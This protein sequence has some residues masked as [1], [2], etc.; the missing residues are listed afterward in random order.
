MEARGGKGM[1][2]ILNSEADELFVR[3]GDGSDEF[4]SQGLKKAQ[5]RSDQHSL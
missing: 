4:W 1:V 3:G 5:K 2:Q